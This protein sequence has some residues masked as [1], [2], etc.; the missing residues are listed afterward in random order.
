[1]CPLCLS[2]AALLTLGSGSAASLA[3]IFAALK[4][5]GHDHDD[6]HRDPSH[7]DA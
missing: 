5:K 3:A 6:D 7:S 1:M 2:A 4:L